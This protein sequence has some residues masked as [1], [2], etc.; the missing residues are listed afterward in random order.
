MGG[1]FTKNTSLETK[2]HSPFGSGNCSSLDWYFSQIPLPNMIYLNR[3]EKWPTSKRQNKFE[4]FLQET[5]V[6]MIHLF[7]NSKNRPTY[8]IALYEDSNTWYWYWK[9]DLLVIQKTTTVIHIY[10]N[11][12]P[13]NQWYSII[14]TSILNNMYLY[15]YLLY[16]QVYQTDTPH[17]HQEGERLDHGKTLWY[18]LTDICVITIDIKSIILKVIFIFVN[19][20]DICAEWNRIVVKRFGC[21]L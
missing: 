19:I 5:S 6:Q 2:F 11:A 15:T 1:V 9:D 12:Y 7:Y 18:I 13:F 8:F 20:H 14:F 17:W 4:R 21:T 10:I 3:M 16:F